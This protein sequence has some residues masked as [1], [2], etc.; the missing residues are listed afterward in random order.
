ML[1]RFHWLAVWLAFLMAQVASKSISGAY[2]KIWFYYVYNLAWKLDGS[3]Q[4]AILPWLTRNNQINA[5]NNG[6][7]GKDTTMNG[8]LNFREFVSLMAFQ[9]P[10]QSTLVLDTEDLDGT[11]M[12]I[13]RGGYGGTV[14]V[15]IATNTGPGTKITKEPSYNQFLEDLTGVVTRARKT[16]EAG[17]ISDIMSQMDKLLDSII[18]I[19]SREFRLSYLGRDIAAAFPGTTVTYVD[20][21]DPNEDP[22]TGKTIKAVD[23]TATFRDERNTALIM[24]QFGSEEVSATN[25]IA[26]V[27]NYGVTGR[28]GPKYTGPAIV[29]RTVLDLWKS[30]KDQ[31]NRPVC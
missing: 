18:T 12:S 20:V 14:R 4:T 15:G 6:N 23:V 24:R 26:W 25:F 22:A 2:E 27:D 29:H 30:A 5:R 13:W 8:Q 7:K 21:P 9:N 17:E 31:V 1:L 16:L 28:D 3:E 11:A 10:A 19:R